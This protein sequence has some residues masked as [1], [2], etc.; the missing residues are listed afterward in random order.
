MLTFEKIP[1]NLLE[2]YVHIIK[3]MQHNRGMSTIETYRLCDARRKE[4][5]TQI[6]AWLGISDKD[7]QAHY[8]F[9]RFIDDLLQIDG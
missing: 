1:L 8:E 3:L 6:F 5:H 7:A 2:R 4:L 9:A